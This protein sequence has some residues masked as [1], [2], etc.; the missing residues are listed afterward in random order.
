MPPLSANLAALKELIFPAICPICGR[1]L[2]R[3][4]RFVCTFCRI[5]APFTNLWTKR[6]NAMEQRFWG[7]VPIERAA[8]F[9]WFVEGSSWRRLIHKAKYYNHWRYAEQLGSWFAVELLRTDF[10]SGIDYIVP[11][12]LHW[13]KRLKRGYNQSEHIAA[14]L[15]K[16]SSI[17]TLF[18]AVKRHIHNPSQSQL[19]LM[20]RWKNVDNIFSVAHPEKL[21]GR[22]IL[23]VDDVFTTGATITSCAEQIIKACDGDV[24]ISVAT[25]SASQLMFGEQ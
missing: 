18:G 4:E 2:V 20:E 16:V 19:M 12:P 10:L 22:H 13:R 3:S 25:I 17:P 5:E 8:A 9:F 7:L 21:R 1:V 23:L 15:S 14:G 11:I 6:E 24:K